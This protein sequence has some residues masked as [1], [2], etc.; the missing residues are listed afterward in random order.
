MARR[1]AAR[2]ASPNQLR[3][4]PDVNGAPVLEMVA[5]LGMG[6]GTVEEDIAVF[7]LSNTHRH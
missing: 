5:G 7:G 3:K 4:T 6:G 2:T 1:P